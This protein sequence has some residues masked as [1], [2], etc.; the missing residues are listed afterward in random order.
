MA[1]DGKLNVLCIGG[2]MISQEMI[3]PTIFQ[4][5]KKGKVGW[6]GVSAL[7]SDITQQVRNLFPDEQIE[8]YPD[9]DKHKPEEK[10]PALYREGFEKLGDRGLVI[11]ATP[12]HL[13]TRM[14]LEACDRG[15]DVIC[16]KPLCLKVEEAHQII[17]RAKEKNVYVF[18]EYHKRHDR[19]IRAAKYKYMLGQLGEMLHGHAWIE[20]PKYMPLDKFKLWCEH[21]S[22]FE[23]IG[24][25]YV[26]AYYYITGLKPKRLVAFGQ[27][28]FL[29]TKGYNAHDAIQTAIEWE[30]GSAFWIQTSWVCSDKNSAMTNQGLQLSGTMGEYW[31]DHKYRN[32]HFLTEEEGFEQYNPNFY[33]AYCGW[34]GKDDIE[35]VGYGYESVQRGLDDVIK[36]H[37]ETDGLSEQKAANKRREIIKSWEPLRPVPEQALI[38]VAVNEGVRLSVD[39]GSTFVRFDEKLYPHLEK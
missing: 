7:T 15:Y 9:P 29:P 10:F 34:E 32:L 23:Y 3:L 30:D 38:G 2:G 5:R 33:K 19:A 35:Y 22:S 11:V 39:N 14:V 20:E 26:D 21:S 13:H 8:L 17:D 36:L 28:K 27:K 4:E 24:V 37:K 6:V 31:S 12:D 16:T 18:T 1:F 25:H